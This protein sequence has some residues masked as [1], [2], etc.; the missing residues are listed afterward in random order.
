MII[1]KNKP[2]HKAGMPQQ[3]RVQAAMPQKFAADF[4][5]AMQD[6]GQQVGNVQRQAI[7]AV[8]DIPPEVAHVARAVGIGLAAGTAAAFAAPVIA[9]VGIVGGSALAAS[10]VVGAVA[11]VTAGEAIDRAD[12]ALHKQVKEKGNFEGNSPVADAVTGASLGLNIQAMSMAHGAIEAGAAAV[13]SKLA[14]M[15]A[16][17]PTIASGLGKVADIGMH[18]GL[19]LAVDTGIESANQLAQSAL[20]R[21]APQQAARRVGDAVAG[22]V[23]A[24]IVSTLVV[25]AAESRLPGSRPALMSV[26]EGLEAATRQGGVSAAQLRGAAPPSGLPGGE[27]PAAAVAPIGTAPGKHAPENAAPANPLHSHP[28]PVQPRWYPR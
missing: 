25:E 13:G 5:R 3:G 12:E 27:Q 16:M 18:A 17:S 14:A 11:A 6:T 15:P 1:N 28:A 24:S 20:R 7:R 21:E 9:G 10:A 19:H 23:G 26:M 22:T 4:Q 2:V 8:A